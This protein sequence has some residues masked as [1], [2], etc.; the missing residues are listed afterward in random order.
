[1]KRP[2]ATYRLLRDEPIDDLSD[3][4]AIDG[5]EGAFPPEVPISEFGTPTRLLSSVST[6][7]GE[8]QALPRHFSSEGTLTLRPADENA[9]AVMEGAPGLSPSGG[10][11]Q[12]NW[13]RSPVELHGAASRRGAAL[14]GRAAGT[15]P[16]LKGGE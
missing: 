14:R 3:D 7:S 8:M 2:V 11:I 6:A 13:R 15:L 9:M 4:I 1:M 12:G 16:P 10:W 5:E